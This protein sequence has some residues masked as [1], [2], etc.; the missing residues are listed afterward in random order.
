MYTL[1]V[2][3]SN[4]S[5]FFW[6]CINKGKYVMKYNVCLYKMSTQYFVW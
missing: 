3:V 4:L 6:K 2:V 5:V 1:K